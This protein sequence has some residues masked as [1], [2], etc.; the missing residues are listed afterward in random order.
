M[1]NY[2]VKQTKTNLQK[3]FHPSSFNQ[4]VDAHVHCAIPRDKQGQQ[5]AKILKKMT[6]LCPSTVGVIA[7]WSW[8]ADGSF[9]NTVKISG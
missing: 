8:G 3:Y 9:C 7:V 1:T 2:K 5:K 4:L 6:G